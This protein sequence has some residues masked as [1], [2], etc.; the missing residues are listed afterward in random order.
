MVLETQ[1]HMMNKLLLRSPAVWC[2]S[3]CTEGEAGIWGANTWE[4]QESGKC[5]TCFLIT[6]SCG[7]AITMKVARLWFNN[8][9]RMPPPLKMVTIGRKFQLEPQQGQA[10][11]KLEH[12]RIQIMHI[13]VWDVQ[14][15]ALLTA[16]VLS[17]VSDGNT[18]QGAYFKLLWGLAILKSLL[19]CNT[20]P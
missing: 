7:N 20:V 3:K 13:I 8:H 15:S 5:Q 17:D 2:L 4:P 16:A 19:F 12:F 10:I 1:E 9:V 11:S 14:V 6:H 18:Q